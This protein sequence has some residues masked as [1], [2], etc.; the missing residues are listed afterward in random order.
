MEQKK[1]RNYYE[2]LFSNQPDVLDTEMV[3]QLLGG[4]SIS[5]ISKLIRGGQ[6]KHIHYCERIYLIPK[7]WLIDYI[8]SEHYQN[9]R[10]K[11]KSQIN[12]GNGN[13]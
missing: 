12:D 7:A 10:Y 5:T 4:V 1:D 11:L 6:L 3:R 2:K 8:L 9:Y 13:E